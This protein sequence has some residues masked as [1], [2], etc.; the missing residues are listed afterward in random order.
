MPY[1]FH[2]EVDLGRWVIL[3][4]KFGALTAEAHVDFY[5]HLHEI[6]LSAF[7]SA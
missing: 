2:G 1:S 5:G 3:M 6:G 4:D 7:C